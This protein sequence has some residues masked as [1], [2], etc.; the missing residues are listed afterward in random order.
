MF[1]LYSAK[2]VTLFLYAPLCSWNIPADMGSVPL[3]DTL[4]LTG[5][6][7]LLVVGV[8]GVLWGVDGVLV[9]ARLDIGFDIGDVGS[10]IIGCGEDTDTGTRLIGFISGTCGF[11]IAIRFARLA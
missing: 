4:L 11:P 2:V 3:S 7:T 9:I 10:G 5:P 6:V 8:W 1:P